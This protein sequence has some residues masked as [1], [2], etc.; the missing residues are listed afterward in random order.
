MKYEI[1]FL[2]GIYDFRA[3]NFVAWLIH[4]RWHHIYHSEGAHEWMNAALIP[5]SPRSE[6]WHQDARIVSQ[7]LCIYYFHCTFCFHF[8]TGKLLCNWL[9]ISLSLQSALLSLL[10]MHCKCFNIVQ[11][12]M[13]MYTRQKA[14]Y[15]TK[16]LMVITN[17]AANNQYRCKEKW[18]WKKMQARGCLYRDFIRHILCRRSLLIKLIV[19]TDSG[20]PESSLNYAAIYLGYWG[21]LPVMHWTFLLHWS[22][23]SLCVFIHYNYM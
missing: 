21:G 6:L 17:S 16:R 3:T 15:Q 20:D 22:V 9:L 4:I 13:Q 23:F 14:F 1:I 11:P 7:L 18:G 2:S 5:L 12:D 8:T 19:R 10:S